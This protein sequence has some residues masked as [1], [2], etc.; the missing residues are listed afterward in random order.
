MPRSPEEEEEEEEEDHQTAGGDS[1]SY[2]FTTSPG[3][4][5]HLNRATSP[6]PAYRVD[7]SP[8]GYHHQHAAC[9]SP[10]TEYRLTEEGVYPLLHHHTT[11]TTSTSS[12]ALAVYHHHHHHHSSN[13]NDN[14]NPANFVPASPSE[15]GFPPPPGSHSPPPSLFRL[16]CSP[17]HLGP[18]PPHHPAGNE[19]A[20]TAPPHFTALVGSSATF[21]AG[22]PSAERGGAANDPTAATNATTTATFRL[23][24]LAESGYRLDLQSGQLQIHLDLSTGDVL[25]LS[26]VV[27]EA[28]PGSSPLLEPGESTAYLQ[29][30]Y[31]EMSSSSVAAMED[32]ESAAAASHSAYPA[33]F[34]SSSSAASSGGVAGSALSTNASSSPYNL[35]NRY[36]ELYSPS[37]Y[38]QYYQSGY[39]SW[40]GAQSTTGTY[41]ANTVRKPVLG[42][43][44]PATTF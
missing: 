6:V 19:D 36:N 11:V 21:A 40:A 24:D 27:S 2:A 26:G 20:D 28:D 15:D 38:S 3:Y 9:S 34:N 43:R 10:H 35:T 25:N 12:P 42:F 22:S 17:V 4:G 30:A 39:S 18:P 41:T 33:Y 16:T 5:D 7:S 14:N 8:P 1:G 44:I 31:Y 23:S 13:N 37:L 32:T 29:P